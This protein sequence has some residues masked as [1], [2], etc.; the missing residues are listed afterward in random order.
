[1]RNGTGSDI[2]THEN[3]EA[4]YFP[5]LSLPVTRV[6]IQPQNIATFEIG[7]TDSTGF[8]NDRCPLAQEITITPPGDS[9]SLVLRA[10]LEPFGEGTTKKHQCGEIAVSPVMF[11]ESNES[12]P[13]PAILKSQPG[14]TESATGHNLPWGTRLSAAQSREV[15]L[16]AAGPTY[17]W[18]VWES[19]TGAGQFPV[20]RTDGG[21]HWSAAGPQL[22][23]DWAGGSLY[24]VTK[25]I[26]E[27]ADAVVMESP[28]VID[29]STDGGR[30][31]YQYLNAAANWSIKAYA[32]PGDGIGLHVGPAS[33]AVLPK[34]SYA[35]Y[36]LNVA[37]HQWRR[38]T[39]SS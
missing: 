8:E 33:W 16:K 14:L 39:L 29:V 17:S 5:Y 20:R 10:R 22:A 27:P 11:V 38:T 24:C 13:Y 3:R 23:A 9:G 18:G 30:Q 12:S 25:V 2:P 36:V 26:P 21:A 34:D 35:L 28:S 7:Y 1:M 15:A 37:S 31:W 4:S 32:A 19:P 6:D